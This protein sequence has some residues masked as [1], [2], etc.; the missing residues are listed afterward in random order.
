[1]HTELSSSPTASPPSVTYRIAP[2]LLEG[3]VAGVFARLG[4]DAAAANL[5]ARALVRADQEGIPSHG[6][7][8]LP[9]YVER[10]RAG[11]VSTASTGQIISDHD[12]ALVLDAQNILGQL[13]SHQ[14]V[15]LVIERATVRGFAA[16][17]VRNG[18]HFGAAGYWAQ[19]L[20]EQGL[21]GIVMSNTRPLM[22]APGGAEPVVGNNP[23]A[24]ALPSA[25]DIPVVLDMAMSAIAMGKIRLAAA[26]GQK[27][28]D[29]WATDATG[30]STTDPSEAIKGMLLPAAGPKGFGLAF[31]VDLLCG[32]L[33]GGGVGS[34]VRPLYG[35]PADP[36]NCSHFFLGIDVRRFRDLGEFAQVVSTF[37]QR[38]R[39]AAR[40]PGV[41]QLYAP[42]EPAWRAAA[43][44]ADACPVSAEVAS[45]LSALAAAFGVP[46]CIPS[47]EIE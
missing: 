4:I 36:Y 16:V 29:G 1:M 15:S 22:P 28:S 37:A 30:R 35:N 31:V 41:E 45:Q 14:A 39:D 33:A 42:G 27:I 9:M 5:A 32:A 20:A 24:I 21:I 26:T 8:L 25:D 6:V 18:F 3:T 10:F 7:M 19:M 17:A 43:A 11:S 44:N 23:M 13:S 34:A 2:R 47:A 46:D 38:V 40:A 12:G